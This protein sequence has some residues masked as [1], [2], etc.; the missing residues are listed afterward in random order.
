VRAE[1]VRAVAEFLQM[2]QTERSTLQP[3]EKPSMPLLESL[4]PSMI[5]LANLG[6]AVGVDL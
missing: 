1:L 6:K 2:L 5:A 3:M 4:D